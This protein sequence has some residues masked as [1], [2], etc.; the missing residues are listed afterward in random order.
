MVKANQSKLFL[1]P[2]DIVEFVVFLLP[3]LDRQFHG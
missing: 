1:L 2:G 3:T